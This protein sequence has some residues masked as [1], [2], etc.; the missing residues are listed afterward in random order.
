MSDVEPSSRVQ[1]D[2]QDLMD[3]VVS[4]FRVYAG[5]RYRTVDSVVVHAILILVI[6]PDR[7]AALRF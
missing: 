2:F 4:L 6:L 5:A 7:V 1:G 3:V